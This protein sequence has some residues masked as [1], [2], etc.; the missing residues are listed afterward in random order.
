MKT[1]FI[2]ELEKF[3]QSGKIEDYL[4][5]ANNK[6]NNK[7]KQKTMKAEEKQNGNVG[8]NCPKSNNL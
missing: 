6:K 3:K 7:N 2:D 8:R 4:E 1:K 5:Y